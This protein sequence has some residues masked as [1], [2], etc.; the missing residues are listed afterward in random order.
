MTFAYEVQFDTLPSLTHFYGG[1]ARGNLPSMENEGT[2]SNPKMAAL[3]SL[4]KMKFVHGLGIKQA[5]LPPQE[6][7]FLPGL[8]ELGFKGNAATV[9]KEVKKE[10]AAIGEALSSSAFM[11][12]ANSATVSPSVDSSEGRLQITPANLGFHLHRSIE[13]SANYTLFKAIFRNP[14][15][16]TVNAPL[17]STPIL[18]DEGAANQMRF[19]KE[20]HLPG[21]EFFVYGSNPFDEG[22]KGILTKKFPARQSFEASSAIARLHGL[23]KENTVFA[24]QHPKAI[25]AGAFHNDVVAMSNL[26]LLII[27]EQ[28]LAF[29]KDV[30]SRLQ[31]TVRAVCDTDLRIIEVKET[32][33]P[34][35]EAIKSYLFNSQILS[36]PDGTMTLLA[37][38]ECQHSPVVSLWIQS[39]LNDQDNPISTVHFLSLK[40]SMLN[41]GGPA[42]LRLRAVLTYEEIKELPPTLFF[43][44]ALYERLKEIILKYYPDRMTLD[45]LLE[46]ELYQKSCAA[47]EEFSRALNLRK[48][49]SFQK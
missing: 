4:E 12:T 28:A 10:Q 31:K 25:D 39:L 14:I 11:W 37:P 49:Y 3:E 22:E 8:I 9:L 32:E 5:V 21:V 42:C 30:L 34:L 6:R 16:F 43:T 29:Q 45:E 33:I 38:V 27:H 23:F 24:L 18:F 13:A 17:P 7:P 36:L 15:F 2:V 41:G 46:P 44:P 20:H 26:N 19:C 35:A 47:L 1:L 48:I 40:Q